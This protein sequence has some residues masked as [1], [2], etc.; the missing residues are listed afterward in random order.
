MAGPV[1]AGASEFEAKLAAFVKD[2]RL[3]GAAASV[4][5]GDELAWSGGA[6]F[7]D[8]AARKPATPRT[9]YRIASITKTFTGTAIMQLRDAGKL[10]LDD[11]VV[12]W[13]PELA[14]SGSP[15]KIDAV[16][17][18]R[19]LSHESGLISEPPGTDWTLRTPIYQG[20]IERN[21]ERVAEI[22]TAVP[23]NT[24]TKYSNLG[25]QLL[26]EV[27]HR[28]TGTEYPD[29]LR[30][31]IL[32]PLGMRATAF[33]PLDAE[34]AARCAIGYNGRTFS[35]E[36]SVAPAL[37]QLFA[38]GGLW[39]DTQDLA[40]WIS[41]QLAAHADNPAESPVLAAATRREMHKPRYLDDD[42]WTSAFG[43]SWYGVRKDDVIWIQH[44]GGLHGF[45]T[46][47]C[48]ERK[49]RVGAIV[50]LNGVANA[51]DLAM[52]LAGIGRRL[53]QA[54]PPVIA[55]PTPLPED[56]RSLVGLYAPAD[57]TEVVRL[58]WRDGKL[59]FVGADDP[60]WRPE[61][62]PADDPDTFIVA[63]GFR[64]S[65]EPVRFCRL[66]GGQVSSLVLGGGTLLR[67]DVAAGPDGAATE[68]GAGE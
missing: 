52:D 10:D 42:A 62:E 39:S 9:L 44:S 57:M 4:V 32:E 13:I 35:D 64:Q 21:L 33:E 54:S 37:R 40:K 8:M 5:H 12:K 11:P 41:F 34:L 22:Y 47:A 50:L 19:L 51:Q 65:G 16:T 61:L 3:Y 14:A 29:Y 49:S 58:E 59:M 46:N 28:A 48:F 63:P 66:P 20:A 55:P 60:A 67:L 53:V 18:R 1:A 43:I 30:Q 68:D 17:I 15:T 31:S 45:I 25:Y 26:G 23:A 2:N 7:A 24:H 27:V 6:G 38:E 36:L 56:F